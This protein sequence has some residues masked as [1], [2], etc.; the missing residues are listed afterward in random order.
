ME[1]RRGGEKEEGEREKKEEKRR[2][3]FREEKHN[4]RMLRFLTR[5]CVLFCG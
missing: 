5:F 3:K 1:R 4:V 2:V